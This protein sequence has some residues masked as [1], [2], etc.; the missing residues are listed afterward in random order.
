VT[1]PLEALSGRL[2][3][4][5]VRAWIARIVGSAFTLELK[6][7]RAWAT[8]L[9][10]AVGDEV[11]WFKACQPVQA[12]EPRLTAQLALR[13]P[14]RLPL[15]LGVDELR[16]WL[17]TA[18]AGVPVG[19]LGN[20]PEAWLR[21]LPRYA[22]VQV[23]ELAHRDEHL[24][25]GVPGLR[26]D[27]LPARYEGFLSRDLPLR[28]AAL[29]VLRGFRPRLGRLVGELAAA[30][31]GESIQ[32]DDLHLNSLCVRGEELRVIDWGDTSIA[33]PFFSLVTTFWFLE[34]QNGLAPAD[35]W[36]DRLRA[37]Y[38][39]PWNGGSERLEALRLA[40]RVGLVAHAIAWLR[41][42][43]AMPIA[44]RPAFDLH[45]GDL[46]ERV[47]QRAVRES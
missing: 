10:V 4:D 38:L 45:F 3:L 27:D 26:L 40:E 31:I 20:P 22:E 25:H 34:R 39:E 43:D 2:D 14:D 17:L 11:A 24:A 47:I 46:L 18:D 8:T 6:K 29:A 9:R 1:G 41:H 13:W 19:A 16:A 7:E 12:F 23:G 36:F 5:A 37:A 21:A 30:G 33:H 42:R 32:H 28:P 35:P 44:E 15:V